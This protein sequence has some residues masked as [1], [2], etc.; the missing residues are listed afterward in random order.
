MQNNQINGI[1]IDSKG[2]RQC[3]ITLRITEFWTL[4]NF[5][6]ILRNITFRKLD[7]FPSSDENVLFLRIPGDG[8][9][10]KAR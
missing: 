7:L 8:K 3:S 4:S 6:L 1:E 2:L 5:R 10:P 9:G